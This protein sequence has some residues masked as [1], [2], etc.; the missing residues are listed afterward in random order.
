MQEEVS[1]DSV[2]QHK[3]QRR[4]D[5]SY[6]T[7]NARKSAIARK[8]VFVPAVRERERERERESACETEKERNSLTIN[9]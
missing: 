5:D 1:S 8:Q 7:P 9:I 2:I 4:E 3:D 6:A